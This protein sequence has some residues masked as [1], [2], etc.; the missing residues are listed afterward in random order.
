MGREMLS[1]KDPKQMFPENEEIVLEQ[2]ATVQVNREPA[3]PAYTDL[4]LGPVTEDT[5]DPRLTMALG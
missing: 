5:R 4:C 2:R 3:S 1:L